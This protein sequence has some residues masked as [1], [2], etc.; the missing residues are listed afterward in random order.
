MQCRQ[1]RQGD[2]FIVAVSVLPGGLKP[3]KRDNGRVI[4]AYGEVT[5]HAHA[6]E[7]AWVDLL[8]TETNERYLTVNAHE[9]ALVHEEHA[10]ITIPP[11]NYR[12]VQQRELSL[13]GIVN[14]SD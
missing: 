14:V 12:V 3:V 6:L 5:G 2:V 7:D 13:E 11:G 8:E 9:A 4:L 1:Y 10:T